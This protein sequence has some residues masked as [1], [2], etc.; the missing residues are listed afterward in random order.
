[1]AIKILLVDDHKLMREG[2][3]ALLVKKGFEVIGEADTGHAAVK[4]VR[5]LQP[6]VI[7][8]DISMPDLNGVEA[9]RQI[10]DEN[11]QIKIIALSMHSDKRFIAKMLAV[12]AKAYLR[13][14]CSSQELSHAIHTVADGHM[15]LNT[16]I[17]GLLVE[18]FLKHSREGGDLNAPVLTIKES[19]VL[20]LIAE[21]KAT[22]EIASHLDISVKTAEKHRQNLM[23]KLG[24]H[25][26]ADLT[27][28]ALREGM[29]SLDE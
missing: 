7:L 9:T 20:Q 13:K 15:Y 8:M 29:I 3:A 16:K 22:K 11:P 25:S 14:N 12:G 4:L 23:D 28:Y 21:G 2:L 26:I 24:V 6:D 17:A 18:D 1:M 19:E 10:R 27:K 5:K